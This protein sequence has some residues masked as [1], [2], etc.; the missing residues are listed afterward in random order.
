MSKEKYY[1]TTAIAATVAVACAC[2]GGI[3]SANMKKKTR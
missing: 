2:V 3:L 1:I